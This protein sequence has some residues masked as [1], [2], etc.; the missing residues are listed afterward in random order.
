MTSQE[1]TAEL[2]EPQFQTAKDAEEATDDDDIQKPPAW[3][4]F[5]GYKVAEG[6]HLVRS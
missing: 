1:Q 3:Y 4:Q 5:E 6:Y 2:S